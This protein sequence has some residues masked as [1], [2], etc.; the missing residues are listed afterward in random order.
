MAFRI[1]WFRT[2]PEAWPY[3]WETA[4]DL[5]S[6]RLLLHRLKTDQGLKISGVIKNTAVNPHIYFEVVLNQL[7]NVKTKTIQDAVK[8]HN[9]RH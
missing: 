8:I 2:T 1:K 5:T 7:D 3:N 4:K 6:A 9:D